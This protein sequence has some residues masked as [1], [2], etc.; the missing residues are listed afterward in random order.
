MKGESEMQKWNWKSIVT[1]KY[2]NQI[3][4]RTILY[5]I[6]EKPSKREVFNYIYNTGFDSAKVEI[7]DIKII[8]V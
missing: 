8:K 6:S 2:N 1:M 4:E 3:F 7:A 5:S